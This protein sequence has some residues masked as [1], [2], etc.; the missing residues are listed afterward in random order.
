MVQSTA[1]TLRAALGARVRRE[2]HARRWTL[3]QLAHAAGVS[4]RQLVTIEQG[5]ANP[6]IGTLLA[7]ADALGVGLP[8]LVAPPEGGAVAVTRA[9][10]GA[11]LWSSDGGSARL[12]VGTQPPDV[13]EL[14][15]W[16]LAPGDRHG[17]DGHADGT[18]E[19]LH[20]LAGT[21]TVETGEAEHVLAVGDAIAFPGDVAHAY[22][23]DADETARFSLAV[24][25]PDV[26]QATA[27]METHD[28][29]H[30]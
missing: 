19:V 3:E 8:A 15:D 16:T 6:S 17:S 25:E 2:R 23:N 18:R 30:R 24:L 26:A 28:D 20:V 10:E 9:G 1:S 29:V 21:V 12:L 5:D 14:W 7:I 27:R 11:V 13:L 4:R 22:R